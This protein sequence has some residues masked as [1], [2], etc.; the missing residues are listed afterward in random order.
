MLMLDAP[1]A[2]RA[3]LKLS[4]ASASASVPVSGGGVGVESLPPHPVKT[5]TQSTA[6]SE[7]R[8]AVA[9]VE[10]CMAIPQCGA[11]ELSAVCAPFVSLRTLTAA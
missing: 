3:M 6:A 11:G 9:W 8:R 2:P 1:F 5:L 4:G 7:R 10:E